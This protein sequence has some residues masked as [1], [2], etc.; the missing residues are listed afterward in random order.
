MA[1]K[2]TKKKRNLWHVGK[3]VLTV[4]TSQPD[5]RVYLKGQLFKCPA[6]AYRGTKEDNQDSFYIFIDVD[7]M[8]WLLNNR[9]EL[10]KLK[11]E[12]NLLPQNQT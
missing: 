6:V 1:E 3:L 8:L 2:Q 4:N 9:K 12:D 11:P 10:N 5:S 7:K